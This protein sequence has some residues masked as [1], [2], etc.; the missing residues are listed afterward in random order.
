VKFWMTL[1]P[2]VFNP[3]CRP[4]VYEFFTM[5]GVTVEG[6]AVSVECTPARARPFVPL[7]FFLYR[8]RF[9]HKNQA[10][11]SALS[12]YEIEGT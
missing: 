9:I 3:S 5:A 12:W 10:M 7:S 1:S 2:I 6:K 8:R 4:D 11:H